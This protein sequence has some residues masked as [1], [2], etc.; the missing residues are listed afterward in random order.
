MSYILTVIFTPL[1][2]SFLNV[3]IKVPMALLKANRFANDNDLFIL[4]GNEINII[5]FYRNH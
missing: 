1:L 4:I 5:F 2:F 3:P